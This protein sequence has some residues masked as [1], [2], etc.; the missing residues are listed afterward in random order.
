MT[1]E[2]DPARAPHLLDEAGRP[3][4]IARAGASWPH[5]AF[6]LGLGLSTPV[7]PCGTCLIVN[8]VVADFA[9]LAG[10]AASYTL[11]VPCDQAL[12]GFALQAQAATFGSVQNACPALNTMSFSQGIAFAIA[13]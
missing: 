6:L 3:G 12:I 7:L 5:I 10:G 4:S 1:G 2:M 9:L 13:E 8:P 11:P